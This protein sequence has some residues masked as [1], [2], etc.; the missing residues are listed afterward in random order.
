MLATLVPQK[1]LVQCLNSRGSTKAADGL[2]ELF[3]FFLAL[4]FLVGTVM[5]FWVKRKGLKTKP[6]FLQSLHC[7]SIT[8]TL[9]AV[10]DSWLHQYLLRLQGC[11]PGGDTSQY[12]PHCQTDHTQ[13]DLDCI[14]SP[15]FKQMRCQPYGPCVGSALRS[16]SE[17]SALRN[18]EY[19]PLHSN[20]FLDASH[21][22]TGSQPCI[23]ICPED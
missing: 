8:I 6:T 2:S 18:E 7:V 20:L 16:I 15:G 10:A 12:Q 21:T 14:L 9:P 5:L 13:C 11:L 3:G 4:H 1:A 23:L 19:S 17:R 22:I